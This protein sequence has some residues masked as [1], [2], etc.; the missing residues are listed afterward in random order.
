MNRQKQR[1]WVP[2]VIKSKKC[3]MFLGNNLILLYLPPASGVL[4]PEVLQVDH[5]QPLHHGLSGI[6]RLQRH[7]KGWNSRAGICRV[8]VVFMQA[9]SKTG[10][11]SNS[12]WNQSRG[13][14]GNTL[15]AQIT[16]HSGKHSKWWTFISVRR[17]Q[18]E[19][20]ACTSDGKQKCVQAC[21]Y[22]IR[23]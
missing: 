6:Q 19:M 21:A 8:N 7:N 3:F 9:S 11:W 10:Y 22:L 23:S 16:G 13:E 17:W 14:T 20:S 5:G 18:W 4:S 2:K 15:K 1:E 12:G